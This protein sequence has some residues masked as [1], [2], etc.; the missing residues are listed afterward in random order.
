[1]DQHYRTADPYRARR[2]GGHGRAGH[3]HAAVRPHGGDGRWAMKFFGLPQRTPVGAD[4]GGRTIKAVQMSR[5]SRGWRVEATASFARS[6]I[7][8]P[9]GRAEARRLAD[10]L[11][12]RSFAGNQ[13]VLAVPDDKLIVGTM[14]LP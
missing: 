1:M 14:E 13:I 2:P 11:H 3:V 12:R 4:I 5:T 6:A 7:N 8:A 9:L 10:V